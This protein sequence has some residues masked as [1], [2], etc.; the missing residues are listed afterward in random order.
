MVFSE[1]ARAVDLLVS[2]SVSTFALDDDAPRTAAGA[3][4]TNPVRQRDIGT[5]HWRCLNRLSDLPLGVMARQRRQVLSLVFVESVAHG[6]I[7]FDERGDLVKPPYT[8]FRVEQGQWR[9]I[10]TVGGASN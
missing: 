2:V 5:Q 9:S 4:A 8:L 6:K 10:R 1:V 7:S 3:R